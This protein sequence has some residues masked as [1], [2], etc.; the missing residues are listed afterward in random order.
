[1]DLLCHRLGK[2][3]LLLV[4][5][6]MSDVHVTAAQFRNIMGRFVSSADFRVVVLHGTGD[7]PS[8]GTDVSAV[9]KALLDLGWNVAG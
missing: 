9:R 8:W 1:M 6:H 3:L 7:S 4:P 5:A 2:K